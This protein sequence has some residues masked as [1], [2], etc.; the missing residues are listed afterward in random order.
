MTTLA[1]SIT[2]RFQESISRRFNWQYFLQDNITGSWFLTV[3]VVILALATLAL[4]VRQLNAFPTATSIILVLWLIGLLGAVA[5]GLHFRHSRIGRWLKANMLGSVSNA[6]LTLFIILVI[7]AVLDAMWQWAVVNATFSPALTTPELRSQDGA[8]W[9]VIVGAW[10]LLM[11]GRFPRDQMGRVLLTVAYFII[12]ALG[13]FAAQR[14][15]LWKRNKPLRLGLT[16]LWV[17]SPAIV[18]ILLAGVP[19][20]GPFINITTLIVGEIVILGL[21]AL[22][23]WQR[24]IKFSWPT[25]IGWAL[26]WPVAYI[27]WRAIGT[28][29]AFPPI[30]VATWGGLLLTLIIASSVILLSFP[31]G[32]VLALGRR[33]EI[34]GIPWWLIW[35]VAIIATIWG[36]ATSTPEILARADNTWQQVLAFWPLLILVL[37]FILQRLFDGNVIAAASTTFIEIIRGVPLITLLFMGIIMAPFFLGQ[38]ASLEN[39]YAVII[40]YALFSAAYMAELIR[41]GLQAIPRG[42]YDAADAIGLNTLQ[43][44]RFIILPQA[45]TIVIPGIVGQFIG[46]YK[47]SSLVAIVGLFEL[48]GITNN[49]TNNPQWLGLRQEL[50]VFV[51][52][53]YFTGSFIMSWYSRRME[54]RLAVGQR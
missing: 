41:G 5:E 4:T 52:V 20:E 6:L 45:I 42:Q 12:L 30:I 1:G 37:A 8:N 46:S 11:V 28:S 47:S 48:L 22:F 34:R 27:A 51:G 15:G 16:T 43:K 24:V 36:L 44:M 9:G 40:A 7:Y 50:Y 25:F 35:P 3:W 39:V 32:M 13:S 19:A 54:S 49:I 18:Y 23:W 10:D 53:I 17:V 21:F 33:S 38:G 26:F 29:G 14:T 2:E 31:L